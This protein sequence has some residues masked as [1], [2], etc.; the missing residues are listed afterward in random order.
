[1]RASVLDRLRVASV[2]QI[3]V[4]GLSLHVRG[5]TGAERMQ[6]QEA[7][8]DKRAFADF[9][10]AAMGLCDE[11]GARLFESADDLAQLDGVALAEIARAVVEASG[12]ATGA[13]E[14]A[15]KN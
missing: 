12:L 9:Q 8:A 4:A 7:A 14:T 1:M 15:K 13:A 5:L 10:I 3:E 6:L 11:S 2:R